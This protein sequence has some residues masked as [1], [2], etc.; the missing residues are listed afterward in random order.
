MYMA[1]VG[2]TAQAARAL[3]SPTP[4]PRIVPQRLL[5]PKVFFPHS[6]L[7]LVNGALMSEEGPKL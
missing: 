6:I 2:N 5:R 3:L 7:P 4:S 1:G